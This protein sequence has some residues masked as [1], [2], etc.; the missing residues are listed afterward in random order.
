MAKHTATTPAKHILPN[1]GRKAPDFKLLDQA[2]DT[3]RLKDYREQWVVLYFYPKDNT[4]GCTK[5]ACQF[6]DATRRLTRR[7]AVVLG[8]SPD[9]QTSH[10]KF[11]V[12]LGLSFRLLADE[13]AT[14][15]KTYGVWQQKT[16]Y[17]RKFMGVVR[18][19]YLIA[20]DGKIAHRWDRVR[21]PDHADDVLA[22][23]DQHIAR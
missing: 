6:R 13:S 4:P 18:T 16:L 22:T 5:E 12:K 1:V 11:A 7:S 3:R 15:C 9:S 17:G 14:V 8:V 19:T 21:V 2:G 20:P 10:E 23:L